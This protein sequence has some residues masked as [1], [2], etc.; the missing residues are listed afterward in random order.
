MNLEV[1][2]P[3]VEE[4]I[5]SR[6]EYEK[7]L[8]V[9]KCLVLSDDFL[10]TWAGDMSYIG[11][12]RDFP[13]LKL[14]WDSVHEYFRKYGKR[15]TLDGMR[16][17]ISIAPISS[18]TEAALEL[19][20]S[21]EKIS[22]ESL[23]LEIANDLVKG[24]REQAVVQQIAEDFSKGDVS[25]TLEK[26]DAAKSKIIS[27]PS[28]KVKDNNPFRKSVA[29][30]N[31]YLAQVV[32]TPLGIDFIDVAL[33]GGALPGDMIGWVMPSKAGKT[34]F[35]W[36]FVAAHVL[37]KKHI[38]VFTFEQPM[39]GDLAIRSS[40]LASNS[41]RSDW[42]SNNLDKIAPD[43]RERFLRGKELW[44]EYLHVYDHW[45]D[46]SAPLISIEH[47]FSPVR[48]LI[49]E[50]KKPVFI[51]LDWWG[52]III[53]LHQ[54]LHNTSSEA[55]K[56]RAQKTWLQQVKGTASALGIPVGVWHQMA[57]AVATRDRVGTAHDAQEDKSFPDFFDFVF[58]SGRKS[59]DNEVELHLGTARAAANSIIHLYLDGE[60]CKFRVK[61]AEYDASLITEIKSPE[62]QIA[63]VRKEIAQA[64][65]A[66]VD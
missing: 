38:V 59:T 10:K 57:G 1:E 65:G 58:T 32:R 11:M 8:L 12:F 6:A 48:D 2:L 29:E 30:F 61:R 40:V 50:G 54:H 62:E 39:K 44:A 9:L 27:D 46:P 33:G 60:R 49:A 5:A 45:V 34:T 31:A 37:A 19:L 25:N 47:M 41:K 56:R 24:A 16:Y 52:P 23:S 66:D 13:V 15:P 26:L 64:Y 63:D 22:A 4:D 3:E 35:V 53:K 14:I 18:N 28:L 51:M 20:S 43:I 7:Q 42:V 17:V 55:D 36:Q 21:F